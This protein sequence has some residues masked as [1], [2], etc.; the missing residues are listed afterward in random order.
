MGNGGAALADKYG[1]SIRGAIIAV[2]CEHPWIE[3]KFRTNPHL[4]HGYWEK[5]ENRI[6]LIKELTKELRLSDLGD[7]YRISLSQI[8][9]WNKYMTVLKRH[10]LQKLLAEA[11]P[12]EKWTSSKLC[13]N[14]YN[15]AA[16]QRWVREMVHI[17]FPDSGLFWA[18]G[19]QI[20]RNF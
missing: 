6:N 3:S 9:E 1:S 7:W 16:S 15:K 13:S 4:P 12:K 8:A 18:G 10:S 20:H 19:S 17:L 14:I 5:K 2:Y 11:Y